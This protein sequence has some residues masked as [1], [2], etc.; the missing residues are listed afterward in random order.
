MSGIAKRASQVVV[1]AL[2][3]AMVAVSFTLTGSTV[4]LTPAV[5]LS[6]GITPIT[7]A[8]VQAALPTH[9]ARTAY[10]D[11]YNDMVRILAQAAAGIFLA[12][13]FSERAIERAY[14]AARE[15]IQAWKDR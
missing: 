1:F 7:L 13:A 9:S 4:P 8:K 12:R 3:T 14:E 15:I 6:G 10:V 5:V 11:P 2:I